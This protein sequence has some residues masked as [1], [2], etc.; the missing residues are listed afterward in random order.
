MK[1]LKKLTIS[2]SSVLLVASLVAPA[3]AS[4]ASGDSAKVV[5]SSMKVGKRHVVETDKVIAQALKISTK[6]LRAELDAGATLAQVA[7]NHGSSAGKITAAVSARIAKVVSLAVKS[8]SVAKRLSAPTRRSLVASFASMLNKAVV[9]GRHGDIG[10]VDL[11]SEKVV[12]DLLG[13]TVD[14]LKAELKTGIS[15]ATAAVNHGVT[16][17]ALTAALTADATNRI[18]AAVTAGTITQAKADEMI[19]AMPA[20]I[21]TYINRTESRRGGD[22]RGRAPKVKELKL[23]SE[24]L[25]ASAIGITKNAL[26]TELDKGQSIAMVAIANGKTAQ[27]VI[28]ALTTSAT[29]AINDA[30]ATGRI[31]QSQADAYLAALPTLVSDFVNRVHEVKSPKLPKDGVVIM[32]LA[33]A[34]STIGISES[35]LKTELK[36]GITI[37]QSAI[38]HGVTV[39]T[40]VASLTADAESRIAV[41]LTAGKI[42]Q[43]KA[44]AYAANLSSAISA[45]INK[46][47]QRHH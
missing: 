46:V 7:S 27:D 17:E 10:P 35:A 43:A 9:S 33:A 38:N 24:E 1:S 19:A 18:S 5:P 42:S 41:A 34:A 29:A 47:V 11:L 36:S 13:I 44:D 31:T 6:Q 4:A 22:R 25:A 2:T 3:A 14:A 30:L 20:K 37:A 16:V 45:F 8:G 40:L 21:T 39:E 28:D 23:V 15:M 26:E 12:A 32:S